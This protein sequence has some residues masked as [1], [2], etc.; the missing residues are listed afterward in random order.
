MTTTENEQRDELADEIA[1]HPIGSGHYSTTVGVDE[2]REIA[3]AILAAGYRKP[4]TITTAEAVASLPAG[5]VVRDAHSSLHERGE[6][7]WWI[8]DG[9]EFY[10]LSLPAIVLWEPEAEVGA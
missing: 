2:A 10:T 7:G 6:N 1:G 8:S 3:D 9:D 4:R 5:T